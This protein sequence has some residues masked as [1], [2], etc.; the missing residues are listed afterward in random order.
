MLC[1]IISISVI[2]K[3]GI[4]FNTYTINYF[5]EWLIGRKNIPNEIESK[6][7]WGKV[8][9]DEGELDKAK[10]VL[11]CAKCGIKYGILFRIICWFVI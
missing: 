2:W 11:L 1:I 5:L 10:Y 7:L 9:A 6:T 8:D 3:F 4:I